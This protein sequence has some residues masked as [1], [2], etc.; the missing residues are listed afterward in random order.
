LFGFVF[1][2]ASS[3]AMSSAISFGGNTRKH[4]PSFR[5]GQT[6]KVNCTPSSVGRHIAGTW[7]R[8]FSSQPWRYTEL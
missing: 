8:R 4:G 5:C 1:G 3:S 6:I 7:I 2:I